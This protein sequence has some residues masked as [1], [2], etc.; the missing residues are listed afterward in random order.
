MKNAR[1]ADG[2]RRRGKS[3]VKKTVLY[4]FLACLAYVF[5]Y[6]FIF[7]VLNSFKSPQ[8]LMNPSINW[9]PSALHMKNYS[10]AIS[11][12]RYYTGLVNSFAITLLCTL[13]HVISG[14]FIGYGFAR[15]KAPFKSLFMGMLLI[16][17]VIPIQIIIIPLYVQFGR[18]GWLDTFMPMVVPSFLGLGLSG[19]IYTFIFRQY[20][21]TVPG[22]LES[23]AYIDGCGPF[24]T[25]LRIIM[26]LS[27]ST[28]LVCTIISMV[29]HWND[30]Y[31][32]V[33]FLNTQNLWPASAM[34]PQLNQASKTAFENVQMIITGDVISSSVVMAAI[35]LVQIPI[36]LVFMFLQKQFMAGVE[37]TG[38]VE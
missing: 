13:G 33:M 24:S 34:L 18:Y 32:P 12:T 29:W 37:R 20:Y 31:Q 36:L 28:I 15:T 2:I 11:Q 4:L 9:I 27:R 26:P 16:T 23:A 22:E 21:Q 35:I 5:L 14:S 17:L 38:I 8:D 1:R 7:M 25:Y 30:Y 6:P 3:F 19:G 10:L